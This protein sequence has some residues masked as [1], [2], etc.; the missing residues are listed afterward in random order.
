M[1]LRL[2]LPRTRR[3]SVHD[4]AEVAL[5]VAALTTTFRA[6]TTILEDGWEPLSGGTLTFGILLTVAIFV[7]RAR[8]VAERGAPASLLL[9][10][11]AG[12]AASLVAGVLRA[13]FQVP[14]GVVLALVAIAAHVLWRVPRPKSVIEF[15]DDGMPVTADD[16]IAYAEWRDHSCDDS[17]A[18]WDERLHLHVQAR[19]SGPGA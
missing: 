10:I 3:Y 9:L 11:A 17:R 4:F 18:R 16:A 14:E 1:N 8:G 19:S 6:I 13:V 12:L 7:V 5:E 15:G 2:I